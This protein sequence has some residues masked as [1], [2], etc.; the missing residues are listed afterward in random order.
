MR[1]PIR[2]FLVCAGLALLSFPA[3]GVEPI[4]PPVPRRDDGGQVIGADRQGF[5]VE[6][7]CGQCHDARFIVSHDSHAGLGLKMDCLT[8]HVS[9]GALSA[10]PLV[11]AGQIRPPED[12]QCG[13]CHGLVGGMTP[14]LRIGDDFFDQIRDPLLPSLTLRSGSV[15]SPQSPGDS[16]LNLKD[17]ARRQAPWDIH[18]ARGVACRDCHPTANQPKAAGA[19]RGTLAHLTRDPRRMAPIAERIRQPD[20]RLVVNDCSSCHDPQ[21]SHGALPYMRRHLQ[22]LA[23]QA[24]HVPEIIG[25]V[26]SV[27]DRTVPQPDGQPRLEFRVPGQAHMAAKDANTWWLTGSVPFLAPVTSRGQ[28]RITPVNPVL[29]FRWLSGTGRPVAPETVARAMAG[30]PSIAQT[31]LAASAQVAAMAG[32][33]RLAGVANP[34]IQAVLHLYPVAH[35][36]SVPAGRIPDCGDCH[37]DRSR[38]GG[39]VLLARTGPDPEGG[40]GIE[41]AGESSGAGRVVRTAAG[42]WRWQRQVDSTVLYVPGA[43]RTGIHGRFGLILFIL[44]L[45][46]V[47]IHA[48]GRK[49]RVAH[50]P[51]GTEPVYMYPLYERIWHW[52][53]ALAVSTLAL[54]GIEI[55]WHGTLPLFDLK[56]AVT[57]HNVL[58]AVLT[59]NAFLSLFFHLA[60]GEIRHF[61]GFNRWFFHEMV[62]QAHFYLRGIFTHAPHPL[63]K[64]PE[65]KFNPLQQLTYVVLLNVLLP[66]QI[67]TGILMWVTGR[68][69]RL[70]D[71]LGGPAGIA[72]WHELGSWLLLSF[73]AVHVY[74]ITTGH[75]PLSAL[76]A[77]VTGYEWLPQGM[78]EEERQKMMRQP[79]LDLVVALARRSRKDKVSPGGKP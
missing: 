52:T 70:L 26:L 40:A 71:S 44:T 56:T 8:C 3:W 5:S 60:S 32:R 16:L 67:G 73:F 63:E 14:P 43:S 22:A 57:L 15:F 69:P 51:S 72:P 36:V 77:M 59:A 12:A 64:T 54:T 11:A 1:A 35:G 33:L 75:T 34:R 65:R 30:S 19:S 46:G 18:A 2:R 55:H 31:P 78:D 74:L 47:A 58:A 39:D 37:S 25:P 49:W 24:C 79:L 53:M 6:R 62:L 48:L 29:E 27:I 10:D 28:R 68:W 20:H 38:L 17:K 66:F 13:A 50:L 41:F 45:L 42:E 21:T 7:T 23:C 9:T 4:H 61:F 76:K